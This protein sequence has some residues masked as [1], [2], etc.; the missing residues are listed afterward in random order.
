MK[1]Y[2]DTYLFNKY[3]EYNNKLMKFVINGEEIDPKS[4][5]FSDV[6]FDIKRQNVGVSIVNVATSKNIKLMR[7]NERL[8]NQFKVFA[9]KD[10]KGKDKKAI[11]VYIDCTDVIKEEGGK[12][13]CRNIDIL[14]S[15]LVNAMTTLIYTVDSGRITSNTD[16]IL[17]GAKSYA[18]IFTHIIDYLFKISINP[19][20]KAKSMYLTSMFFCEY[21]LEK[22]DAKTNGGISRRVSGISEREERLIL[23]GCKADSFK[24]LPNF[25]EALNN[26]LK[27]NI[28]IDALVDK[29]M[30][31]YGPST[32]FG[33]EYFP[34]FS[35]M[36]T[37]AYC[38][39]YINNQKTI[40]K[41][42]PSMVPFT[43]G[44]F[45]IGGRALNGN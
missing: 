44:I 37:D 30:F 33:I 7:S 28:T 25:I 9:A 35:A 27:I 4:D 43:N 36:L 20:L 39:V 8:P 45:N 19:E 21:V 2:G 42:V 29:W 26:V 6:L 3:G 13:S 10:L 32:V 15:Y 18:T 16:L 38:G 11:K 17:D 1:T 24:S 31:I 14:L 23:I 40:E 12:Y 5:E 41:L 22:D 34:A